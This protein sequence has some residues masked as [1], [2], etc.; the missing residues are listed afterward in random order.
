MLATENGVTA[1]QSVLLRISL[2][3]QQS[4]GLFKIVRS[5]SIYERPI[6][7]RHRIIFYLGHLEAFDWN[8]LYDVL[9]LKSFYSAFDRLFAFGIDPVGGGLPSDQPSDWPPV[10]KVREYVDRVRSSVDGRLSEVEWTDVERDG[11]PLD[12][13]LNV[14]IEHRLMHLETLAYMLHQLPLSAKVRQTDPQSPTSSDPV[15]RMIKIPEGI[16]TLGLARDGGSF[17]WDNEYERHSVH[18]PGF[19]ID[20]YPVTNQQFLAFLNAGGYE[21]RALW[22]DENWEWKAKREIAQPVFWRKS[23]DAWLYRTMFDEIPLPAHWPAYVS[24]AEASAYARWAGKSLP[25]EEQWH[26]AAYGTTGAG[27]SV[28]A[29]GH[30][31]PNLAYGNFNF[32]RWNPVPVNAHPAGASAFGV[33]DMLGNGWEWTSTLFAPFE[34]FEPFPFYR[35][36]SADFFDGRHFVMKGGSART[37]ACMLRP[38]FRNWFQP[39]YQYVYAGFRCVIR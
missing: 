35:G 1:Q 32:E 37:A 21:N 18:V 19:E 31:E 7:E 24:H 15:H 27:E 30:Q 39:R 22:T 23:G 36:Y 8:L 12:T 14:A 6:P 3:R 4:D 11:F 25:S 34:G 20:R 10:Q 16:A 38:T 33:E 9:R 13:L 26:R 17:G 5:D 2:A 28:Y 29:W